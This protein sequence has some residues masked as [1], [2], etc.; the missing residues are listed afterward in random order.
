M[1]GND[2]WRK[3]VFITSSRSECGYVAFNIVMG[4]TGPQ[5]VM[6]LGDERIVIA[7]RWKEY[8]TDHGGRDLIDAINEGVQALKDRKER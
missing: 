7:S 3:T 4:L 1:P 2:E 8:T 5:L 6:H